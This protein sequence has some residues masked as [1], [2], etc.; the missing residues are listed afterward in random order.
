MLLTST[1]TTFSL[2]SER[3]IA[4]D[5]ATVSAEMHLSTTVLQGSQP[6]PQAIDT[7]NSS[8]LDPSHA[9]L[10]LRNSEQLSPQNPLPQN[11]ECIPTTPNFS[12][13]EKSLSPEIQKLADYEQVCNGGFIKG[14]ML[15]MSMPS[16]AQDAVSL[17]QDTAIRINEFAT[18]NLQP[19]IIMEPLHRGVPVDF[20]AFA[21]GDFDAT[22]KTFYTELLELG[23]TD[24]QLGELI[25]FPEANIPVWHNTNP[26][27]FALC[28][29]KLATIQKSVFPGSKISILLDSKSYPSGASWT[30][31]AYASLLPYISS[32]PNGL[33]DSFG[34][35]GYPWP[36]PKPMHQAD[37]FLSADIA[38]EAA[39]KLG[40]KNIWF[41]TGTYKRGTAWDGNIYTLTPDERFTIFGKI[42]EQAERVKSQGFELELMLFSENKFHKAEGNDWSYLETAQSIG[43]HAQLLK[44]VQARLVS[45]SIPLYIFDSN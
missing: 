9:K 17:A 39:K 26:E 11:P 14:S 30:G 41:N 45:K 28:V 5:K 16:D 10:S 12:R 1:V 43:D 19:K 25:P 42:I 3:A 7:Q 36:D 33:V 13:F 24:S 18:F 38:I 15:F 29:T 8:R 22:M 44:A 35:Q 40:V 32:I 4:P 6:R 27:T 21:R 23:I 31:G 2:G 37:T 34:L 20:E